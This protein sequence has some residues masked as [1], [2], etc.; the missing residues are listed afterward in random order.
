MDGTPPELTGEV[1]L[2]TGAASGIGRA[3]VGSLLARGAAVVGLDLNPA[4]ATLLDRPDFRGVVCDVTNEEDLRRAVAVCVEAFGGLDM[5][6]LNAGIFPESRRIADMGLDEWRRVM[7]INLD[8]NLVLMRECHP[9]LAL[10]P[11]GGRVVVVG[12]KNVPAPGPGRGAYSASKAALNQL[13]RV[14][15][16]EWGEGRHPD[17][18][19]PSERGLRH[20]HLDRRAGR[21]PRQGLWPGGRRSTAGATSCA[22]R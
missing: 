10:A 21:L 22:W 8:S 2:V 18:R 3:C 17:Q 13:A 16:L 1:A 6:I 20:R 9:L 4:I 11:R 7:S 15:A 12:S 19:D 5:L 14:A